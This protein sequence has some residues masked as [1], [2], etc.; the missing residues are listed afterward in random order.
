MA[1]SALE[2]LAR[3]YDNVVKYDADGRPS[4][5]VKFPKTKSNELDASLPDHVHPAF[6]VNG[7]EQDYILIGKY[8]ASELE[9]NGTLYSLPNMPPRHSL[10]ADAFLTRMRA[11][12]GGA[13]GKTVA[14]SGFLLLLAQKNGWDP[15]GNSDYGSSNRDATRYEYAKSVAI[16]DK[17]SFGGFRYECLIAHTTSLELSPDIAPNYWKK[18]DFIGGVEAYPTLK[19]TNSR[20]TLLTL[21]GSGLLDWYLDG[22]PGSI[23]DAIGNLFDQ[24]YGYRLVNC[25][26]QIMADNNAAHPDADL[27]ATSAAWKAILPNAS[28]DGYTLVAPGTTGT[29]HWNWLNGKITLDTVAP[30]FDNEYRGTDFKNLAVNSANLPYVPHIMRELGLFPTTGSTMRGYYYVQFTADE[31][32]PRRGG[33]Y[34]SGGYA[35]LGCVVSYDPRSGAAWRFGARPRSLVSL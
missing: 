20:N 16:G 3:R 31:R 1:N 22:T 2:F 7:V 5:F 25:E 19:D 13:S 10:S 33:H 6:I 27:S 34:R 32:F 14:D 12:G 17:R 4:I 15:K 30:T 23:A 9:T 24:D 28:D 11:F 18:L 8:K 21:T 26:I 35:G 29:L